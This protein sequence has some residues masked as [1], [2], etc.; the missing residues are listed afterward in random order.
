M[1]PTIFSSHVTDNDHSCRRG[2]VWLRE[3]FLYDSC[4]CLPH[5]SGFTLTK[6]SGQC[7]DMFFAWVD[8][9]IVAD[10]LAIHCSK[11]GASMSWRKGIG[12]A[13][14][15]AGIITN[16]FCRSYLFVV[17]LL[18]PVFVLNNSMDGSANFFGLDFLNLGTIVCEQNVCFFSGDRK[19]EECCR[20]LMEVEKSWNL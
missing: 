7:P 12:I 11:G 1:W 13:T 16:T 3:P 14:L 8:Q 2:T 4:C 6:A 18:V 19:H 10:V 9:Q 15:I 5:D 20:I 17:V